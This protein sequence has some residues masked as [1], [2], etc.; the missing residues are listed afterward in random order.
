[1]CLAQCIFHTT[2]KS[3]D[4]VRLCHGQFCIASKHTASWRSQARR[5]PSLL[6]RPDSVQQSTGLHPEVGCTL[7][8]R[9]RQS[10]RILASKGGAEEV[11]AGAGTSVLRRPSGSDIISANERAAARAGNAYDDSSMACIE[12]SLLPASSQLAVEIEVRSS[13]K[14]T[15]EGLC[16]GWPHT[17]G[18][19]CDICHYIIFV[20]YMYRCPALA[21]VWCCA[22]LHAWWVPVASGGSA[23]TSMC[24]RFARPPPFTTF[25][26]STV[27]LE[28][29]S[30]VEP[31][32]LLCI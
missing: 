12:Y 9:C 3:M 24:N 31:P 14:C 32:L 21:P 4:A 6:P 8:R 16:P 5:L 23:S 27:F 13:A 10:M 7:T 25:H 15:S 20:Y 19:C 29:A 28:G 22:Q 18:Y 2:S 11:K 17:H 26:C 30:A 1:M